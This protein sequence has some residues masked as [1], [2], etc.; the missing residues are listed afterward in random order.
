MSIPTDHPRH[1][2]N[3]LRA[4]FDTIGVSQIQLDPDAQ[5][6]RAWVRYARCGEW[7]PDAPDPE[8]FFPIEGDSDATYQAQAY[9]LQCPVRRL[10]D[11]TATRYGFQGVWGG[12]YRTRD[13]MGSALCEV[14]G[15]MRYRVRSHPRC[16]RCCAAQHETAAPTGVVQT[17]DTRKEAVAA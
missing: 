7:Q 3:V 13:H 1:S 10:C 12:I 16:R 2:A 6:D 8:T 15:C 5:E 14:P 4:W 9:C 11:E 17:A